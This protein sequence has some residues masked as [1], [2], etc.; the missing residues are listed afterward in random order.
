MKDKEYLSNTTTKIIHLVNGSHSFGNYCS[1]FLK[2]Q[3]DKP[4]P[5]LNMCLGFN[6]LVSA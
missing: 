3:E 5:G 6:D 4:G 2:A 1:S